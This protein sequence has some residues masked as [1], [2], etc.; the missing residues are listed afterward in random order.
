[1]S[2]KG[3]IASAKIQVKRS[4]DEV[5]LFNFI[6][7]YLEN[8]SVTHNTPVIKDKVWDDDIIIR[9]LKTVIL[10]NVPWYYRDMGMTN[11]SLK[12]VQNRDKIKTKLFIEN[13]WNVIVYQDNEFTTLSAFE[14]FKNRF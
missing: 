4:K 1:M 7:D 6:N 13:N 12:Q 14:D 3:G 2:S 5:K 8:I 10:W 9:E 11:H